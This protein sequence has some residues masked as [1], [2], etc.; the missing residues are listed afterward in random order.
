M[1]LT[2]IGS[3]SSTYK[4]PVLCPSTGRLAW[5]LTSRVS[6]TKFL[7]NFLLDQAVLK[8]RFQQAP[9][10]ATCSQMLWVNNKATQLLIIKDLRPSKHYSLTGLMPLKR[11]SR[12]TY[13]HHINTRIR[14]RRN[15]YGNYILIVHLFLHPINHIWIPTMLILHWYLRPARRWG[16]ER[17][18]TI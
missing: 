11:R 17:V 7:P 5:L 15:K 6:I 8:G 13:L 18:N 3:P 1:S 4:Y 14:I 9:M 16:C 12:R 2:G 10:L